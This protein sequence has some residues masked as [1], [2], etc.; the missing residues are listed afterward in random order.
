M[1]AKSSPVHLLRKLLGF[2]NLSITWFDLKPHKGVLQLGIKPFKNGARCPECGR[3]CKLLKRSHR[4][5]AREMRTWRDVPCGGL[6]VSLHY[7]PREITCPTHGRRQEEIPWA[8][9]KAR[10]TLRLEYEL[11]RSCRVTTQKDACAALGLPPSTGAE[12]LHRCVT[13]SRVG[14]K[15]RGL[16]HIGIDE[17][18]YRKGHR[19]LTIVY[20]LERRHIIWASKGRARATID[21]FFQEHLSPHQRSQVKTACCDMS[22]TYIGAI[23]EHLP[24]ALLILDR[25]HVIKALNEAV[26]EVRKEIWRALDKAGRKKLKGLRFTLL[27]NK[28]NRT[29]AERAAIA[30]IEHSQRR[31][32]RA[33][34]LKDELGNL[35]DYESP[36]W[37]EKFLK[38]WTKKALLSRI[39]PMRKFVR[40]LKA[41]WDGVLASISGITNAVAEGLNRIIR[42]VKNRASGYRSTDNFI[43]MIYLVAGDLDLPAQIAVQNRTRQVKS[44]HHNEL[45]L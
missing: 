25:F 15:I 18:S 3:R 6:A 23:T 40:T 35:W 24:D 21:R 9:P 14:H 5:T 30:K 20:D 36:A 39:E 7:H 45:C 8:A 26:D 13:R 42:Q 32:F 12:I 11:M 2:K 44:Q 41:H 38:K 34:T 22:P 43:D 29:P 37:A 10:C 16:K 28:K 33:T 27:K 4:R 17:I 1:T 19:Y 31:I